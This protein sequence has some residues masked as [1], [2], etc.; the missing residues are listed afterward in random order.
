[1]KTYYISY[2]IKNEHKAFQCD[3]NNQS[4]AVNQWINATPYNAK[5]ISCYIKKA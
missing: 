3:A 1:M 5:L 4:E 2:K